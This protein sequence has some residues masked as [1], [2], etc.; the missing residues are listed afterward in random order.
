MLRMYSI[1]FLLLHLTFGSANAVECHSIIF[2]L[3]HL[4]N[5]KSLLHLTFGSANAVNVLHNLS[6]A[7]SYT[8][9]KKYEVSTYVGMSS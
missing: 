4:R 3:L 9:C 5:A 2:L 6:F 7:A 1:I 8:E